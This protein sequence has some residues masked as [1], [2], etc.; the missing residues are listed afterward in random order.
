VTDSTPPVDAAGSSGLYANFPPRLNALSV[1][2]LVLIGVTVVIFTT[3]TLLER[4]TLAR[5]VLDI[6][7]WLV[8]LLYE[9]ML[10]W[11]LGGTIGHRVMNLQ[12]VDNRTRSNVSLLK[13]LARYLVKVFLGVFSFFTMS[14]TRRH[15]AFHDLVTNSS[16]RIRE[17]RKAEPHQYTVGPG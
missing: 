10:V 16:V 4:L 3:A 2:A 1:D 9:P 13:A 14:F 7:W 17:A 15:Q 11:R 8:L 6:S 12:V 5:V